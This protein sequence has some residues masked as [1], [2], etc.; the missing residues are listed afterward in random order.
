MRAAGPALLLLP[1]LL[2]GMASAQSVPDIDLASPRLQTAHYQPGGETLLTV[3]PGAGAT[4]MLGADERVSRVELSQG[5]GFEVRVSPEA[6]SLIVLAPTHEAAAAMAVT[7]DRR[8]YRFAL[9]TGEGL[10]AALLV[11]FEYGDAAPPPAQL[12][13]L[14]PAPAAGPA[15]SYRLRGDTTVLPQAIRDDARA[16]YITYAPEQAL[17]AVFAIGP[18]GEEEMVNG[19]MRGDV[20]VIDRVYAELVFRLDEERATAR[21]NP[22]PDG[23]PR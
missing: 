4:V 23:Q 5:S 8:A 12:A 22:Q 6:N 7:T 15:W 16:T 3:L 14:D 2:T 20:F 17:P 18:T 10:T 21:R 1:L 9:R 19:H 13:P 11:R